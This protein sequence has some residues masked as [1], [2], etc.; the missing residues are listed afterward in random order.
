VESIPSEPV[1]PVRPVAPYMGGKRALAKRLVARISDIPHTTYAEPFVGMGGVFFRLTMRPRGEFINDANRDLIT[2]FRVLQHHYVPFVD[3]L[4]YQVT[5][6]GEFELLVKVGPDTLTDLQRAA[7]FLYIQRTSFA[8]KPRG[9]SF[10]V[11]VERPARF[12]VTQVV[13]MLEAV[14]ERLAGVTIE[15][16][17][18]Q[19]F[20][21]RY[22]R[23]ETL[24]Y[25]DPP[26]WGHEADYGKGIFGR[27]DFARIAER[28]AAIEGRF[29]LSIN[30]VPEIRE[31]FAGFEIEAVAV[32]YTAGRDKGKRAGELI[33]SNGR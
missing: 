20:V 7:R 8:G 10:G 13:P 2:L 27:D 33:I 25:L 12:D 28:L 9:P 26:Y 11:A 6:P 4:R 31:L 21:D 18:W 15:C 22:D 30:D 23:P 19:A 16:L 14:H 24:F 17:E 1:A 3:M 5:S 32:T 29:L